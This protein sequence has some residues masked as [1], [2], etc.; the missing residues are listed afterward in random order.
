M[1]NRLLIIQEQISSSSG[2]NKIGRL[3]KIVSSSFDY[4]NLSEYLTPKENVWI[5]SFRASDWK[6]KILL[7][8]K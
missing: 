1:S 8:K 5:M 3:D 2:K 4:L 7:R 6:S